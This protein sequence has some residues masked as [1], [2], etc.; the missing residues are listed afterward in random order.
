MITSIIGPCPDHIAY[1][2]PLTVLS[3]VL[4]PYVGGDPV[5]IVFLLLE[6]LLLPPAFPLL[7][8]PILASPDISLSLLAPFRHTIVSSVFDLT[9]KVN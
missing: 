2:G 1:L 9:V 5:E 7:E 4:L 3:L 6:V 8:G